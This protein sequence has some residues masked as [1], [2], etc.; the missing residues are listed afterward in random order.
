MSIAIVAG[1]S[2]DS[3]GQIHS[4]GLINYLY[5]SYFLL[6]E[7]DN[8][9]QDRLLYKYSIKIFSIMMMMMMMANRIHRDL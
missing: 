6:L 2:T 4:E 9:C 8:T 3:F 1:P 5:I 7:D